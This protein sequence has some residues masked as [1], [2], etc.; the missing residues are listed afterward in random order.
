M[1]TDKA[2]RTYRMSRRADAMEDTRRRITEAIVALH[3]SIGPART[4]VAG[5]AEAAGVQRHTVYR[6]FPTEDDQLAACSAHYWGNHPWPDPQQWRSLDDPAERLT[7]ALHQ[8]YRFY[9]EVEPMLVNSLRDAPD[10]PAVDRAFDEFRAFL[11]AA[12][13][14]LSTGWAPARGRKRFVVAA[15][16][17]AL[18]FDTWRSL[19]REAGLS[20]RDAAKLMAT[21]VTAAKTT[22]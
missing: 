19:V 11:D 8:L 14:L 5:I 4:T 9:A 17:H 15:V 18:A 10:M 3:E 6:Y 21:M 2:T 12:T 13:A 20:T 7:L 22:P 16:R 1:A